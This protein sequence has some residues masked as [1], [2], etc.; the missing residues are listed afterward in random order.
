MRH[1][2]IA[3][4]VGL[5]LCAIVAANLLTTHFAKQGHPEVSVYTAFGLVAFD[6]VARDLL[7]DFYEG[8]TRLV[9]LAA[10]IFAGALLSYL[11]N[12]DSAEIAKWSA[13]AFATAMT[14]DSLV[15]HAARRQPWLERSNMSNLVAAAVDSAVFCY[16][17]GFP[18]I[19]AFGQT[20]AKVAG[21]VLFSLVLVHV[22]R[23]EAVA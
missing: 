9:V 10:L 3:G 1:A 15:Y 16:G 11:A 13:I 6:Y 18:F 7:H 20:T 19:V 4:V 23:R 21:G 17:V 8:R 12:P 14:A 22:F 2:R 5:Y